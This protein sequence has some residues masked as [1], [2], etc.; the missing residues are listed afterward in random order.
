MAKGGGG[1]GGGGRIGQQLFPI[2]PQ[3]WEELFCKLNF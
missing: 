3:K 2:F 1:E